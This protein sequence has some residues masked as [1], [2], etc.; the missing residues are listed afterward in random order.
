MKQF[1]ILLALFIVVPGSAFTQTPT[2][3]SQTPAAP[4]ANSKTETPQQTIKRMEVELNEAMLQGD[5]AALERLL[6]D[7]WIVKNPDTTQNTKA[8]LI[9][10]IKAAGKPWASIKDEDVEI[11]VYGNAAIMTGRSTRIRKGHEDKPM[12]M[13]ITRVYAKR[14]AGWQIVSMH[15]NYLTQ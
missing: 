7:D 9:D 11:H 3:S 12:H 2:A 4:Q 10:F 8:Q 5:A 6:A 13:Q 1:I 15:F 14:P